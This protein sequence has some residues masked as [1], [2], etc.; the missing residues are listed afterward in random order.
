MTPIVCPMCKKEWCPA[1]AVEWDEVGG[2]AIIRDHKQYHF[3]C[4]A[5][6]AYSLFFYPDSKMRVIWMRDF[7]KLKAWDV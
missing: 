1:N 2:P 7:E 6:R 3:F 4:L 5:D